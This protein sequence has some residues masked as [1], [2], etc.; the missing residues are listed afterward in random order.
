MAGKGTK[1]AGPEGQALG[2]G[3]RSLPGS[4]ACV[5]QARER[6]HPLSPQAGPGRDFW[7]SSSSFPKGKGLQ[8]QLGSRTA[9]TGG[10]TSSPVLGGQQS[11]GEGKEVR[12]LRSPTSPPSLLPLILLVAC[13]PGSLSNLSPSVCLS[14]CPSVSAF[15]FSHSVSPTASV[16]LYLR[17]SAFL[18]LSLHL[19]LMSS[20]LSPSPSGCVC[21]YVT[22]CLLACFS[23][24]CLSVSLL[25]PSLHLSPSVSCPCLLS[26]I[27]TV[28]PSLQVQALGGQLLGDVWWP[29]HLCCQGCPQ[30]RW[31]RLHHRGERWS[32]SSS[33]PEPGPWAGIPEGRSPSV[34]SSV[35][36]CV[37][38]HG[39]GTSRL[40][41]SE[42]L[43]GASHPPPS[44]TPTHPLGCI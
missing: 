11:P 23:C 29:G 27:L 5:P 30:Q 2:P 3:W 14:H 40:G 1:A 25:P 42:R 32:R 24:G 8:G 18:S 31:Q 17:F 13:L 26:L 34:T 39:W 43:P 36:R 41:L 9:P 22:V 20:C 33:W 35:V 37:L 12:S 4:S 10:R 7:G 44:R 6:I 28:C 38:G 19:C 15:L 16:S 21:V